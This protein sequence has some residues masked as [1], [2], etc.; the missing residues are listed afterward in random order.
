MF[1]GGFWSWVLWI[2]V[3]LLCFVSI[4]GIPWGRVCYKVAEFSASPFGRKQ[5]DRHQ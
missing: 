3:A 2:V 1:L 4:V 5:S